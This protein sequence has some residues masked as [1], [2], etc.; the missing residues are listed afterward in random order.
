M[1]LVEKEHLCQRELDELR[2]LIDLDLSAYPADVEAALRFIHAHLFEESL[3]ASRVQRQEG[4]RSHNLPARFKRYLGLGLRDYIEDRRIMAAMR[5]LWHEEVEIYLVAAAVGYAHHETFTRAFKRRV[6]CTPS[7]FR[8]HFTNAPSAT[9][10]PAEAPPPAE[11][12]PLTAEPPP[13][14][15]EPPPASR[16]TPQPRE[17]LM[18]I[19]DVVGIRTAQE[20]HDLR[21]SGTAVG[22]AEVYVNATASGESRSQVAEVGPDGRWVALFGG[23]EDVFACGRPLLLEVGSEG[24]TQ[25]R[26]EGPLDCAEVAPRRQRA[27]REAPEEAV[28]DEASS[29]DRAAAHPRGG[30]NYAGDAAMTVT[31]A[32]GRG[33][34]PPPLKGDV[35]G[36]GDA[37]PYYEQARPKQQPKD[38]P[39]RAGASG[40][41]PDDEAEHDLRDEVAALRSQIDTL[42]QKLGTG[43]ARTA[44]AETERGAV[45]VEEEHAT[46]RAEDEASTSAESAAETSD[47]L[48]EEIAALRRELR[49][50][51]Q[52]REEHA[53]DTADRA[54]EHAPSREERVQKDEQTAADEA[55]PAWRR[56]I[57]DLREQVETLRAQSAKHDEDEDAAPQASASRETGESEEARDA[58]DAGAP[59]WQR[60]IASLQEQIEALRATDVPH[61]TRTEDDADS[62]PSGTSTSDVQEPDDGEEPDDAVTPQENRA[63]LS[64]AIAALRERIAQLE[65]ADD[66]DDVADRSDRRRA[67]DDAEARQPR[68]VRREAQKD[69]PREESPDDRGPGVLARQRVEERDLRLGRSAARAREEP[70]A[71]RETR[72]A[73]GGPRRGEAPLI[74]FEPFELGDW[75]DDGQ[76]EVRVRARIT[77]PGREPVA[78]ELTDDRDDRVL[79]DGRSERGTLTLDEWVEMEPGT[80]SF[81][82]TVTEP[83]PAQMSTAWTLDEAGARDEDR[84][85]VEEGKPEEEVG[86][87]SR[88][89]GGA[90][91]LTVALFLLSLA[92]GVHGFLRGLVAAGFLGFFG[93]YLA[94]T[95]PRRWGVWTA[96][97]IGL[98]VLSLVTLLPFTPIVQMD[99]YLLV[100]GLATLGLVGAAIVALFVSSD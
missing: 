4:L 13:R 3:N 30:G 23:E 56:E 54:D 17:V 90:W 35:G 83:A 62:A 34:A 51:R 57:R 16:P 96:A 79:A 32:T 82:V 48:R 70:S 67:G 58:D 19:T 85:A 98:F 10:P 2:D 45:V 71:G 7:Q 66:S 11:P 25:V 18:F 20:T 65:R 77:H 29:G 93:S 40:E 80:A 81:T 53:A 94:L 50:Q 91:G 78:A 89:I 44:E 12:P 73:R 36:E 99:S 22:V 49:E 76:R 47:E 38:P 42:V 15:A 63:D 95:I 37:A 52:E 6:G 88:A 24:R 72:S 100:A 39:P 8:A 21:V 5:L 60:A 59:E 14:P 84:A 33:P 68:P 64:E 27:Q 31:V 61:R 55:A 75:T 92:A 87:V 97:G 1:T 9:G 43:P 41:P 28:A 69:A 46:D 86:W 74:K 26:W